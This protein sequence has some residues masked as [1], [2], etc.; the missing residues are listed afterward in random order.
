MQHGRMGWALA[1]VATHV[2][3][4][5]ALTFAGLATVAALRR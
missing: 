2:L 1:T 5:L 4:S 3:G